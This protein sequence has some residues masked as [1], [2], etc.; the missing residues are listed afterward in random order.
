MAH[1]LPTDLLDAVRRHWGF[2]ALRPLQA[3]AIRAALDGRDSL[4]VLPT[5]GGKSLCYQAPALIRTGLTVV[6]SPLI[7]L[8]K[9]QVDALTRIGVPA[10]RLDST[11]N[12][13][14]S[15]A[16]RDA[17]R[18]G[19]VRLV[20]TSPERLVNTDVPRLLQSAGTHTV[21]VDEAHCVSH[22][23]HDFRPEYRQLA[24]LRDFFPEAAMH[25]FTATATERVR[26]DIAGQLGL[27]NPQVLVGNFDRPNLSYRVLP[28]I[29]PLAQTKKVIDR[30]RGSAGIVYCLR[31]KD[32][33]AMCAALAG[34]GYRALPYHAGMTPE[35]RRKTQD[36]FAA[37]EADIVV[38]TVAF[39]MGI[40]RSNVRFVI[41]AAMPKSIEHYQQETGRAG[42]DGLASECVLLY[43]GGDFFTF[44]SIIEK[45]AEESGASPEYVAAS[46]KHLEDMGRYCRGAVC[47]H[48]ALV[49]Y[50]G[51]TYENPNC[52]ACDICLGDTEDVPDAHVTAQKILSCVARVKEGFG[53]NHVI[54][55]LRG[56]NSA[57][58]RNRGHDQLS[59]YGLL[60]DASKDD[61]RDWIF[62]LIGQGVLVQAGD[63]YPV[64]KLNAASWVV[65]KGQ[66]TARLIQPITKE[67]D[68]SNELPEGTDPELFETL[69]QL[70]R[71]KAVQAAITPE[72]VFSDSVLA[73]MARGRPTTEAAL[74]RISGVG[75]Y[76]LQSFGQAFLEAIVA[77]CRRTGLATDVPLPKQEAAKPKITKPS[78]RKDVAFQMY[79]SGSPIAAVAEKLSV[80]L[81]TAT[82]YLCEFIQVEKPD[83]IFAWVPEAVCER[84]A[85]AAE[86]HG[87]ARLKPVFLEMNEEVPYEQIRVVFAA[88]A[89]AKEPEA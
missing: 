78:P 8:M 70:R 83:S 4:V 21:A 64:L 1:D 79:R 67:R 73:E 15:S 9:D 23:G 12:F 22:W 7:A 50:F 58:I 74:K 53:V 40:D 13:S 49:Q 60:R 55:V 80:A 66:Q 27:R 26:Q 19:S 30:H 32:V 59:T 48:R 18:A 65:M 75:D 81:G 82:E 11:Q 61:L 85:A 31:R 24:R 25:A 35:A 86:I 17:I 89:I 44:K 28:R 2:T 88:L 39:G 68:E 29:D 56:V 14:E 69:R 84:V 63:Q 76:R 41:H 16:V 54:D 6:V 62:Q 34:S 46:M 45:S 51:Q 38:A 71:Q 77:H 72:L 5:G 10:A 33:D 47:R 52:G 3:Q 20:F 57:A 36:A 43:S 87:T 42:R 37:E